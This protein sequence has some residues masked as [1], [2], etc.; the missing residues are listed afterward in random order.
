MEAGRKRRLLVEMSSFTREGRSPSVSG[1]TSSL[2]FSS[3][4]NCGGQEP[5]E[6]GV[7]CRV[8]VRVGLAG[9]GLGNRIE[10]KVTAWLMAQLRED[11]EKRAK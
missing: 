6:E 7:G 4:R 2:L 9:E 11:M 8:R 1:R 3:C 5:R 10:T